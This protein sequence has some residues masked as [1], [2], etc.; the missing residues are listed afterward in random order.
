MFRAR[1]RISTHFLAN[2]S[3]SVDLMGNDVQF[4]EFTGTFS[5]RDAASRIAVINEFREQGN[6]LPL[7]WEAQALSVIIQNFSVTYIS[8]QW[9]PYKLRCL[10]VKSSAL[11]TDTT[12]DQ[13]Q[14]SPNSILSNIQLL[15]NSAGFPLDP[16]S[17]SNIISISQ[18][19]YDLPPPEAMKNLN[20]LSDSYIITTNTLASFVNK[21]T[22]ITAETTSTI[23]SLFDSVVA[24][25]QQISALIL[26]ANC[27]REVT[28]KASKS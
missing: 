28:S 20:D 2:G 26:A 27:I 21:T 5:G 14:R 9:A 25:F 6:P 11:S 22:E 10:V 23:I 8:S 18:G 12:P 1:D 15:T 17:A 19:S 13:I 7:T 3:Y 16:Q 4:I 24:A